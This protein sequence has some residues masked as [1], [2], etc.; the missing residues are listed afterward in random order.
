MVRHNVLSD[1]TVAAQYVTGVARLKDPSIFPWPNQDG[2]SLYDFFVFWH[3]RAMMLMTPPTQDD[4]NSAHSGPAFLPW[5]RYMLLRLEGFLRQAIDDDNFRIPYWDWSADAELVDP[6]QSPVW[7]PD[8]LGQFVG[9]TWEV[10]LA[11]NP[12]G[13]NPRII[14]GGRRLRRALGALLSLP[15]RAEVRTVVA[16]EMIYDVPPYNSK[17]MGT[18]NPD[19]GLDQHS[20]CGGRSFAQSG[21]SVDR[22]RYGILNVTE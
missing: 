2:L 20:G 10:R 11:S 7:E 21:S 15:S 6:K 22:W 9:P 16:N 18:R 14:Q 5:H 1:P 19:R 17:A 8:L 3:H 4:R 12:T 13:R